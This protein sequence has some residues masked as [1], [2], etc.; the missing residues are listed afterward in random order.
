MVK[1]MSKLT[2]QQQEARMTDQEKQITPLS[3]EMS[4]DEARKKIDYLFIKE[5]ERMK[6]FKKLNK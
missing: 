4:F 1:M 2:K 5:L 3:A 6:H